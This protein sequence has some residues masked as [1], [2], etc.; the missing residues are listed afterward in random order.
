MLITLKTYFYL[1]WIIALLKVTKSY[2]F[3]SRSVVNFH[4]VT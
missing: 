4:T 1:L 3:A 2:K